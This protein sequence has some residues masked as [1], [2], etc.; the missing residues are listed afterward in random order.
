MLSHKGVMDWFPLTCFSFELTGSPFIG[1]SFTAPL[2]I[3]NVWQESRLVRT[4]ISFHQNIA[5]PL[6]EPIL[7]YG[8]LQNAPHNGT[9]F[10]AFAKLKCSLSECVCVCVLMRMDMGSGEDREQRVNA[11]HIIER[12]VPGC[13]SHFPVRSRWH[14]IKMHRTSKSAL[15]LILIWLLVCLLNT[16][17]KKSFNVQ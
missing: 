15:P 16:D 4:A 2:S 13:I 17:I 1:I 14:T 12:Q 3:R 6:N 5:C 10:A 11:D 9:F 7:R 8:L